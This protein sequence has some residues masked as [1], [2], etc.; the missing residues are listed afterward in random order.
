MFEGILNE[1]HLNIVNKGKALILNLKKVK[2]EYGKA[3]VNISIANYSKKTLDQMAECHR[4]WSQITKDLNEMELYFKSLP[5][6]LNSEIFNILDQTP[7]ITELKT[8]YK[9]DEMREK[10]EVLIP[11]CLEKLERVIMPLALEVQKQFDLINT[12]FDRQ[13]YKI[14]AVKALP[15]EIKTFYDKCDRAIIDN[16]NPIIILYTDLRYSLARISSTLEK[17]MKK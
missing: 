2:T 16:L 8:R 14:D 11:S 5:A 3:N 7:D 10:L 13:N 9:I 1:F 6:K 12:E 15:K 4:I 17:R